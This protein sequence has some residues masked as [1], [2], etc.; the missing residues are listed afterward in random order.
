[1]CIEKC[2]SGFSVSMSGGAQFCDKC[3]IDKIKVVDVQSG[4]CVCA[5]RHYLEISSD[6]CKPCSYDCMTCDNSYRCLTCDNNLL[7]TKRVMASDGRCRCPAVGFYDDKSNEDIVCQ[8]C[9]D[10]CFTCKGPKPHDCLTCSKDKERDPNG[11][12]VCRNGFVEDNYGNCVCPEPR[13][14]TSTNICLDI[15]S[16]CKENQIEQYIDLT[17]RCVCR[18]GYTAI[19]NDCIKCS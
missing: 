8:K 7:Q 2:P 4:K 6:S 11:F 14:L 10:G 18:P 19:L 15:L 16:S 13:K 9:D 12:C 17:R 5:R 1:M 3:D